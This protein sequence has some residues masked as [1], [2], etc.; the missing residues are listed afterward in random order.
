MS[1]QVSTT[2]NVSPCLPSHSGALR[3]VL[4]CTVAWGD[5]AGLLYSRR[6][7]TLHS[8]SRAQTPGCGCQIFP[9]TAGHGTWVRCRTPTWGCASSWGQGPYRLV[10]GEMS[11]C[12]CECLPHSGSPTDSRE[13]MCPK[14]GG[15]EEGPLCLESGELDSGLRSAGPASSLL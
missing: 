6:R 3:Q 2:Q 1:G 15:L 14:R 4:T 12:V 5:P 8:C 13:Q 7:R 10:C 11:S 9:S